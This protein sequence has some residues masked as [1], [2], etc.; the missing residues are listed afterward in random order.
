MNPTTPKT[1]FELLAAFGLR[2]TVTMEVTTDG[3]PVT[4]TGMICVLGHEDG[5]GESFYGKFHDN[6]G[7]G[8]LVDCY[9]GR[10]K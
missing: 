8:Q 2:T 7:E 6:A 3:G 10:F 1:K 9:F 4:L 5:S